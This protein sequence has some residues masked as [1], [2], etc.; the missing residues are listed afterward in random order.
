MEE[1]LSVDLGC[2]VDEYIDVRFTECR[3]CF[4]SLPVVLVYVVGEQSA[5]HT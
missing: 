1:L 2:S 5:R 3:N 4:V